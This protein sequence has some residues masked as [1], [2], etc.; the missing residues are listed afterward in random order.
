MSGPLHGLRIVEL[1]GIGPGPH[2]AM[3]LGDLGAEIVRVVRP[4]APESEYALTSHVLRGRTTVLADL[5]DPDDVAR[6]RGLVAFADV[7]I[8]GFR[9]GVAERLG[10]GPDELTADNP[11][12]VYG[13]MTG[14]GQTGPLAATAGHDINYISLTGALDAIGSAENPLP[15]L[16]LVGDFGGG[17]MFLVTGIL[18]ALHERHSSG[19]GQVVDC[20]MVDGVSALL[21]PI[22]ELRAMGLW[23]DGRE[24]NL[25]DGGAP[26][27][28][29]YRC[30]D[31][32]FMAVGAVEPQFWAMVLDGLGLDAAALPDR[33]DRS[34]WP[35]LCDTLAAAFAERD[36]DHWVKVFDGTD[37]CVTPVLTFTE[38]PAH[39]HVAARGSL[40]AT[41]GTD[42]VAGSAPRFSRTTGRAAE[43]TAPTVV[44]LDEALAAWSA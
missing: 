23:D 38:A 13:R 30:S 25:L 35:G 10:L 17:S 28:R 26:F 22:H 31:G 41:V 24:R 9:P 34:T 37:A 18:A 1:A 5:K 2:A 8:E 29:T 43:G 32:R 6:V 15:P 33:D 21:Q 20:A 27:Y 3:M 14:W 44:A 39:P 40:V 7:L 12:L 11:R 16:N 19:L 42:V 36:R 4:S